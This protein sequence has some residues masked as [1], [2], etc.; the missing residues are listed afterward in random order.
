[1]PDAHVLENRLVSWSGLISHYDCL[2]NFYREALLP[3]SPLQAPVYGLVLLL[4]LL[5]QL[6]YSYLVIHCTLKNKH[7]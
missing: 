2:Y 3:L 1:M 4:V 7:K 6:S 5:H